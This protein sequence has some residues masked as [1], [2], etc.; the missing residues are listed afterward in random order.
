MSD[1]FV[2]ASYGS[3]SPD[4]DGRTP[5]IKSL[6]GVCKHQCLFKRSQ[7][8]G[9]SEKHQCLLSKSPESETTTV[10]VCLSWSREVVMF[11]I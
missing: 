9:N 6:P 3:I 10:P 4:C 2:V 5:V 7:E 11:K 8:G 1:G